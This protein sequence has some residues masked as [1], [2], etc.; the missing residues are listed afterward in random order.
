MANKRVL[1]AIQALGF[2]KTGS[3]SWIEAHG[4]QSVGVSTTFNL[5][6]VF[7]L[8]QLAL[9]ENIE[10]I[11]D[12][13]VTCE[14]VL[15]GYPLLLHLATQGAAAATL[16]GRSTVD[17]NVA[18]SIFNDT[19]ENASGTP[20]SQVIMSGLVPS[21][22]SYT[23]PVEGNFTESLTLIGQNK[24]WK[25]SNFNFS[26]TPPFPAFTNRF[27]SLDAPKSL[28]GA[29]GGINRRQDLLVTP[30]GAGHTFDVNN[31]LNDPN[32]ST[33]PG[34][35]AG[36]R[37]VTTSGVNWINTEGHARIQN[38]TISTD[39]N[40][41]ALFELGR[42][43]PFFR[44][45]NFPTEVT[46]EFEVLS[47]DG[48]HVDVTEEGAIGA[49]TNLA[50][51]TI[52]IATK[53]GTRLD[54]GTKNKLASVNMPG[55]DTGGGNQTLTYTFSNFNELTVTHYADPTVALRPTHYFSAG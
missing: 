6:Q 27:N 44:Y 48:D 12:V 10:N 35:V 38:I 17:C 29:S 5:E 25:T 53:E 55:G 39:F 9:Y 8:G 20:V 26:G 3:Q 50:N 43:T 15:D 42:F 14:K 7:E 28:M 18:L 37:G 41:E 51:K 52:R 47:T 31:M 21:S 13:E 36:I 54:L 16:I 49:G 45:A 24:V 11:P 19:E 46:A 30:T 33:F 2:A 1:Y 34:G 32:C 40:R 23:F 22:F 4:V